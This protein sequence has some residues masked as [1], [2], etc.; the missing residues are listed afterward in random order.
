MTLEAILQIG[1]IS[2]AK[3]KEPPKIEIQLDLYFL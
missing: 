2:K 1:S 3:Q